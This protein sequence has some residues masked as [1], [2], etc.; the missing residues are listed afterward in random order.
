[1]NRGNYAA[2][3]LFGALLALAWCAPAGAQL[4]HLAQRTAEAFR[5]DHAPK[6]DGTLDDPLWQSAKPITDFHQ[7][8]GFLWEVAWNPSFAMAEDGSIHIPD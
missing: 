4:P 6:L 2:G 7:R 8:E 3:G 1:M 5:V